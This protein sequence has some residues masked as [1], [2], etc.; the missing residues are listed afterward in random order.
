MLVSPIFAVTSVPQHT[1]GLQEC[2]GLSQQL[3]TG[4]RQGLVWHN[5]DFV[6]TLEQSLVIMSHALMLGQDDVCCGSPDL[7]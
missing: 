2:G 5:I 4:Y 6:I 7:M 3:C 1:E